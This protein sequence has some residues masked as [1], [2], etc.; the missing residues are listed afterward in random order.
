MRF[1]P[2]SIALALNFHELVIIL[3]KN[4]GKAMDKKILLW[5]SAVQG[6]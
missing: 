1:A 3:G 5:L 6:T 2:L 4:T